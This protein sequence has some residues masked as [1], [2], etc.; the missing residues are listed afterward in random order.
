MTIKY[1]IN[2]NCSGTSTKRLFV[3]CLQDQLEFGSVQLCGGVKGTR[4][5]ENPWS[6][7]QSWQQ[8]QPTYDVQCLVFKPGHCTGEASTLTTVPY[9]LSCFNLKLSKLGVKLVS[10]GNKYKQILTELSGINIWEIANALSVHISVN[11][12]ADSQKGPQQLKAIWLVLCF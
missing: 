12:F 6:K 9:M 3:R 10:H 7:G 8:T 4:E 1:S 2:S 11:T 5:L